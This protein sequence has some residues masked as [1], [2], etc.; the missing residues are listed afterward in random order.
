[1]SNM[2]LMGA[3]VP[4][5]KLVGVYAVPNTY[6]SFDSLMKARI[7]LPKTKKKK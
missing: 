6:E 5:Y 7:P 1:M 4:A 3:R 2:F